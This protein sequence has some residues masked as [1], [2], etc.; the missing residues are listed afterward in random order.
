MREFVMEMIRMATALWAYALLRRS[1][2]DKEQII[3]LERRRLQLAPGS[4]PAEMLAAVLR[5]SSSSAT[6]D[7]EPGEKRGGILRYMLMYAVGCWVLC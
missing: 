4:E 3:A 1:R 6:A 7:E 5:R 2:G